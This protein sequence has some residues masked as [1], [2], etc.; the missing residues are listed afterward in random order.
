MTTDA[1][2]L[3]RYVDENSQAAF[4]ELV[5]RHIKLVYWTA[6]RLVGDPHRAKD[7]TQLVFTSLAQKARP[8]CH[9]AVLAGW[10]HTSTRYAAA[11][12][13]RSELRRTHHEQEA[14]TMDTFSRPDLTRTDWERLRPL[15]DDVIGELGTHE[16]DAVSKGVRG[17]GLSGIRALSGSRVSSTP[18]AGDDEPAAEDQ[19]SNQQLSAERFGEQCTDDQR[20]RDG[21]EPQGPADES[22]YSAF[23]WRR[24]LR[25]HGG[26]QLR[27]RHAGAVA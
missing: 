14:A 5:E 23:R 7:V 12:L 24:R 13:K 22:S 19:R 15:I 11:N 3:R 17:R 27:V 2:L 21:V 4:T 1:E 6:V 10:L 16:R 20:D 26:E 8:L 9:H 25:A 18:P